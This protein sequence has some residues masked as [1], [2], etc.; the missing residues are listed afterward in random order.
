ML[1]FIK[2]ITSIIGKKN[3]EYEYILIL[4]LKD[5]LLKTALYKRSAEN[6]LVI[7]VQKSNINE[8]WDEIIDTADNLISKN[9]IGIPDNLIK[10][11]VFGL[12]YYWL[13][14]GNIKPDILS[15]LKKLCSKLDLHPMGFI[16]ITEAL[17]S[18]VQKKER[19]PLTCILIEIGRLYNIISVIRVG[20][21][22]ISHFIDAQSTGLCDKIIEIL[23]KLP[24]RDVLPSR[25]LLSDEEIDLEKIKE[26]II[27]YPWNQKA[28]FLHFP[29]VEILEKNDDINGIITTSFKEVNNRFSPESES[30]TINPQ[31]ISNPHIYIPPE[32]SKPPFPDFIEEADILE[33]E[34]NE[35]KN[36]RESIAVHPVTNTVEISERKSIGIINPPVLPDRNKIDLN[37][38]I[39]SFLSILKSFSLVKSFKS[40]FFIG[41]V[42]IL[43]FLLFSF[44]FYNFL[45]KSS[46]NL[47]AKPEYLDKDI[48]LILSGGSLSDNKLNYLQ[49][50]ILKTTIFEKLTKKTTGEKI[51]GEKAVGEIIIYNKTTAGSKLF[52]AGTIVIGPEEYEYTI[53]TD[54]TVPAAVSNLESLVFGKTKVQVTAIDFGEEYNLSSGRKEFLIKE[55]PLTS[56]SGVSDSNFTG[57]SS[58]KI[59]VVSSLDQENLIESFE[60]KTLQKAKNYFQSK[61]NKELELV[62]LSLE[63]TSQKLK[64]DS[65]I[66]SENDELQLSGEAV[67]EMLSFSKEALLSLLNK[68]IH[69]FIS[70]NSD[71]EKKDFIYELTDIR[72]TNINGKRAYEAQVHCRIAL[73]PKY[74]IEKIKKQI[75]GNSVSSAGAYLESLDNI[76]G[77]EFFFNL[78]LPGKLLFFPRDYK[79]IEV[80]IIIKE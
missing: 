55:F 46:V 22:Q 36:S 53:D 70:K 30:A 62:E 17:V 44:I 75:S 20:K 56:Y 64:F 33:I 9:T 61:K 14:E 60:K 77:Y 18:E 65:D 54:I 12:P 78:R 29:K 45:V 43:I 39:N 50:T 27:S 2:N 6:L 80:K 40:I 47:Y 76:N 8:N 5:N 34:N 35:K 24:E 51:I 38:K 37:L 1:P 19:S 11:T 69:N 15:S 23:R 16:V 3:P 68:E 25:I 59:R 49:T 10:N 4:E 28:S 41:I 31:E 73:L 21:I 74:D 66:S 26:E 58:S 7:D 32:N 13:T 48:E 67:Y 42:A 72:K 71:F 52:K 79:N 57:G 63:M